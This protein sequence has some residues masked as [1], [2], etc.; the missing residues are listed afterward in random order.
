MNYQFKNAIKEELARLEELQV[1]KQ[2]HFI[3][4]IKVHD[5]VQILK[6]RIMN[7]TFSSNKFSLL[8]IFRWFS[9]K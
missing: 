5:Y 6:H 1:N 8:Q 2:S 4:T 7:R 9:F 3:A